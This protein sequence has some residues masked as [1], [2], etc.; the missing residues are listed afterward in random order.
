VQVKLSKLPLRF[1]LAAWNRIVAEAERLGWYWVIAAVGEEVC[2]LDPARARVRR[3]A[4]VHPEA[5]I[6]N[7]LLWLDQRPPLP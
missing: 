6:D 3:T 4:R 1:T 7:L 5:T 2:F